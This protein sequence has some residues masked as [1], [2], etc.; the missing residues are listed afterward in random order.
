MQDLH[1]IE[2]EDKHQSEVDSES[3]AHKTGYSH[4]PSILSQESYMADQ[5]EINDVESVRIVQEQ[6]PDD[7]DE[8][9]YFAEEIVVSK[10]DS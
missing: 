9:E 7:P 6:N 10:A 1:E 2:E 8:A 5:F 4:S 3:Q